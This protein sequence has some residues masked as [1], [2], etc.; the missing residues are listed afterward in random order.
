MSNI[1]A[2]LAGLAAIGLFALPAV[3]QDPRASSPEELLRQIE[4]IRSDETAA[5]QRNVSAFLAMPEAQRAAELTEAFAQREA[6]VAISDGLSAQYSAN[7]SRILELN[8]ELNAKAASLGLAEVFGLSR[9]VAGDV[10]VFLQQSL[11]T[12]QFPPASG[13]ESRDQ[14]LRDFAA[15]R[16]TPVTR[17]IERLWLE[18]Q[19]EIG[20]S[21]QVVRYPVVVVQPGGQPVEATVTRIGPFTAMSDGQYLQYLPELGS[22]NVL[23]RQLPGEFMGIGGGFERATEGYP[24]AVVDPFRGVTLGLYVE[25]PNLWQR[26]EAG[27]AIGYVIIIVGAA[28]AIAFLVQLVYLIL[29]RGSVS[30]QLKNLDHPRKDNPLGRVLLAFRG[31]AR[32]IEEDADIA[33]LRIAEAV[34]HETP[35]LERFQPFLRLCVAAGPLLGLIGTVWGMIITFQSITESGSSDP[36]L[37]ATG[38]GTAMIATLLGLGIAVPLLF[39]NALLNSLSRNIVQTLDEQS[40]GMLAE[41]LERKRG[42]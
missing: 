5:F 30:R 7:E 28:G 39:A 29:V 36:R 22:L 35:I 1:R 21:G 14:V 17:D 34:L 31:D 26:V 9:E 2:F 16:T 13:E 25:R 40:A 37:M 12:T 19:R 11:I 6:L 4:N 23:P 8:R 24:R 32:T 18:M 41:S 15:S 33:E 3:A 10:A 20:A 42:A 27:E 38:I